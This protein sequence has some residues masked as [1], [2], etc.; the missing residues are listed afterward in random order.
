MN[1]FLKTRIPNKRQ[2]FQM[3]VTVLQI[4]VS[5]AALNIYF[6][7]IKFDLLLIVHTDSGYQYTLLHYKI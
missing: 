7:Q 1:Y 4:Q 3:G 6:T 5:A 2:A